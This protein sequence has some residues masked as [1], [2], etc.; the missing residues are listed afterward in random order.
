MPAEKAGIKNGDV[1]LKVDDKSIPHDMSS[2]DAMTVLSGKAGE[3]VA[4]TI[5]R[6]EEILT[7]EI[8]RAPLPE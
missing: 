3:K 1:V 5:K 2:N 6:G 8:E 7:F 4:L